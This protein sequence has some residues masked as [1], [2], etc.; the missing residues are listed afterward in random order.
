VGTSLES[1]LLG[2]DR[3]PPDLNLDEDSDLEPILTV[4]KDLT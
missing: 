3:P 2:T 1:T 4:W